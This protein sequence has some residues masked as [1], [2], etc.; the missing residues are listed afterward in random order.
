MYVTSPLAAAVFP[1][2]WVENE[3]DSAAFVNNNSLFQ[4]PRLL[5]PGA[6]RNPFPLLASIRFEVVV[7]VSTSSPSHFPNGLCSSLSRV[8]AQLRWLWRR[9]AE[10]DELISLIVKGFFFLCRTMLCY[11]EAARLPPGEVQSRSLSLFLCA[12]AQARLLLRPGRRARAR[13]PDGK[14]YL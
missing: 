10:D 1:A 12:R 6:K 13:V 8:S 14:S 4:K 7:L 11:C 2:F 9:R 3:E 5:P